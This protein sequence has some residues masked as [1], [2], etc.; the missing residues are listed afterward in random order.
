MGGGVE[1][2]A[3]ARRSAP[4]RGPAVQPRTFTHGRAARARFR[5]LSCGLTELVRVRILGWM[6]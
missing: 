4:L 3:S 2:D 6:T 5:Q 1:A